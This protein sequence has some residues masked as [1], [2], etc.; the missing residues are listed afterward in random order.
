MQFIENTRSR[1]SLIEFFR[2][3]FIDMSIFG[4]QG[5]PLLWR[6]R[7]AL[8]LRGQSASERIGKYWRSNDENEIGACGGSDFN[9]RA[10]DGA[11]S[12]ESC[13]RKLHGIPQR[14]RLYGTVLREFR[15]GLDWTG[16]CPRVASREWRVERR[17]LVGIGR[18]CRGARE[19][20]AG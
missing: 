4:H 17:V 3:F 6:S 18:G 10:G 1:S 8:R 11:G 19:R 5:G 14:G 9:G 2:R 16:R 20:D 15:S 13:F 12:D 7:N